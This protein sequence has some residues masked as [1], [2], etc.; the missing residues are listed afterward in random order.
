MGRLSYILKVADPTSNKVFICNR[1][2]DNFIKVFSDKYV[3]WFEYAGL[4]DMHM[5]DPNAEIQVLEVVDLP[6]HELKDQKVLNE[7]KRV[8]IN[9]MS[10]SEEDKIICNKKFND[11]SNNFRKNI[12]ETYNK[13]EI[14]FMLMTNDQIYN[15]VKD[16]WFN[17]R[18]IDLCNFKRY[19][20]LY[21][22]NFSLEQ[23]VVLMFL[24]T[25]LKNRKL[26]G[27]KM[28]FEKYNIKNIKLLCYDKIA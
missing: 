1:N 14:D 13:V 5:N 7:K 12:K 19:Q 18:I 11:F 9:K 23:K 27:N 16:L 20:I 28:P 4:S 6:N 21:F 25:Y 10:G 3:E 2:S 26:N 8:W 22:K 24:K 15:I 17:Y